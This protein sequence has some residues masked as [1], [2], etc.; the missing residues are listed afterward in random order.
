[1]SGKMVEYNEIVAK[2]I[3]TFLVLIKYNFYMKTVS[4]K[5]KT[6]LV[7]LAFFI[8]FLIIHSLI[9]GFASSDDPYYH[10][11]HAL[12]IEQSGRLDLVEPWL[13]FHFF[14]YAPTDPWWGFHLG[15]ALFIHLFGLFSG[16]KIFIS[17]LGALVFLVFYLILN[18]LSIKYPLAWTWLL[19]SASSIF[20]HRLFLERPHLLSIIVL[21]L[22]LLLLIKGRNFWLFVLSL[23]YALCYDLAPMI[24]L[25]ALIYSAAEAR[26]N[27]RINLKP[28][29]AS[30]GGVLIGI[31][32]HPASLNYLYVIFMQLWQTFFLKFT[33][34]DLGIG[35]ESR[36]MDFSGFV[37]GNLLVL[38]FY[39]AAV[40]LFLAL[41]KYSQNKVSGDFLFLYSGFWFLVTLAVPR[42]VEYWLP[43]AV[44]FIALI[45]NNFWSAAEFNQIWHWLAKRLNFKVFSFFLISL[46]VLIILNNLSNVF[47]SIYQAKNF[48]YK[49][50]EQANFWLK[51]HTKKDSII[52]YNNWGMW[53]LMFFYNN[54]NRYIHG[55]DPTFLYEYDHELFW[56]W[57]NISYYGLYCDRPE[58]CLDASPRDNARLIKTA[59]KERFQAGYIL[60]TNNQD[61]PLAKFLISDK[62]N[63]LKVFNNEKVLIY[64]LE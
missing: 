53:P 35:G 49:S 21:P 3:L 23:F 59:I 41:R 31:I 58:A 18:D 12:L 52:F 2:F 47:F 55:I 9:N 24:I 1:M 7:F 40:V 17:L 38:L 56:L 32:I 6:S 19:F 43:S 13:E 20:T 61:Q 16:V 37:F 8:S 45:F 57:K 50:F 15:L 46:A 14:N 28:L 25:A 29:I 39:E 60:L 30:A 33:G 34:I 4:D 44:L 48:D 54:H 63:F 11:K 42:G 64:K 5:I 36:L 10:A 51:S 27:R 22:A 62:K 26:A